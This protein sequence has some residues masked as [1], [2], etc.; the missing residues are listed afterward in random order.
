MAYLSYQLPLA[1]HDVTDRLDDDGLP[2]KEAV[3]IDTGEVKIKATS[4]A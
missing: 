3:D 1:P 2:P 4:P